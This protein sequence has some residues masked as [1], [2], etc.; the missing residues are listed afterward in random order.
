MWTMKASRQ[1]ERPPDRN[2]EKQRFRL[3]TKAFS[4]LFAFFSF[5]LFSPRHL[6]SITQPLP[7]CP[8]GGAT[9]SA[10]TNALSSCE[11]VGCRDFV[12]AFHQSSQLDESAKHLD[13]LKLSEHSAPEVLLEPQQM[14]QVSHL[15][16][17]K[18]DPG[19]RGSRPA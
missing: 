14:V 7:S 16:G 10:P 5:V 18:R 4:L 1:C 11:T 17:S 13:S 19:A 2:L 9:P 15:C 12:G 3:S 6:P 8:V